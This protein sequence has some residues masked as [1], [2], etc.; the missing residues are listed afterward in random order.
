MMRYLLRPCWLVGLCFVAAACDA[1]TPEAPPAAAQ[2][3]VPSAV[4]GE[5]TAAPPVLVAIEPMPSS[6]AA[7]SATRL[8]DGRVLIAGGCVADG[9]EEGIADDANLFDPVSAGFSPAGKLVQPRVGHR[10]I[11]LADGSILL[12][13]GWTRTGVTDLVESYAPET[14]RFETQGRRLE[15]RDGFREPPPAPGTTPP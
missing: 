11:A 12:F 5:P 9:C 8:R 15:P 10:A 1:G 4:R 2:A 13:G 7:H 3:Q 14:G 6:R